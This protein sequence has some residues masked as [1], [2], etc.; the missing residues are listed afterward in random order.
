M[1][2]LCILELNGILK[3]VSDCVIATRQLFAH[4]LLLEFAAPWFKYLTSTCPVD[5]A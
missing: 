5:S 4:S 2:T 3:D 1:E